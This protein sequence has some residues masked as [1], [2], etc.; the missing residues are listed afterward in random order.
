MPTMKNKNNLNSVLKIFLVGSLLFLV[1]DTL[2]SYL[3]KPVSTKQSYEVFEI[4][5]SPEQIK[6][7]LSKNEKNTQLLDNSSH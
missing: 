4:K 1:W 2:E 6:S 3:F 5:F 7:I